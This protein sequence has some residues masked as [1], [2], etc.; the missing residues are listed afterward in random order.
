VRLCAHRCRPLFF[1]IRSYRSRVLPET[2][3]DRRGFFVIFAF[4]WRRTILSSFNR[5]LPGRREVGLSS[6]N[7]AGK[8]DQPRVN[9]SWSS[10][11][12]FPWF[13]LQG[14]RLLPLLQCS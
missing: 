5:C 3:T 1:M 13:R 11:L 2:P 7:V 9:S 14:H 4:A 6:G 8:R 10:A 12:F